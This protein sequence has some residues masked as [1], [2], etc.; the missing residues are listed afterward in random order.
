MVPKVSKCKK[1]LGL[2]HPLSCVLE[3]V[4]AKQHN[5]APENV[6]SFSSKTI[7]VLSILRKNLFEKK[8]TLILYSGDLPECFDVEVVK[9][10][11]GYSFDLK[12]IKS[13]FNRSSR[14]D[15]SLISKCTLSQ[16]SLRILTLCMI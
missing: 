7:P 10:V 12:V 16:F 6:I 3:W 14:N 8:N 2:G 1:I 4:V 9:K 11:Y 5:L 15:C 13:E